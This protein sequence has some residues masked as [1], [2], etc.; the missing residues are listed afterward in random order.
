[1]SLLEASE[2]TFGYT[3][4]TDLHLDVALTESGAVEEPRLRFE[5][6]LS[7]QPL[8]PVAARNLAVLMNNVSAALPLYQVAT[9]LLHLL[10]FPFFSFFHHSSF[11][12]HLISSYFWF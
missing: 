2:E 6:S 12:Y 3:W 1:V 11:L 7:A 8:N 4:L 10:L 5:R 9:P